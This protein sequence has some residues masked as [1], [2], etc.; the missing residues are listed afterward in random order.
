MPDGANGTDGP[1][2]APMRRKEDFRF[3]T[4]RGNYTDD[5]DLPRQAC[6]AFVRSPHA[7]AA[8]RSVDAAAAAAGPGVVAILTG[9]DL[10]A[11][12]L[13]GL[14]CGWGVKSKDGS[15]MIEPPWPAIAAD[16]VRFVGEIV[17]VAIAET[18]AEARDAAER[19][20]V[21][22]APLPAVAAAAEA[23]G[24]GAPQ[25]H[26]EAAGNVCFDWEFGDKTATDEAFAAAHHVARLSL[27]NQRLCRTRW[28]R[29]RRS[30]I[31]ISPAT[32]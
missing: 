15:P 10:A 25:L 19:V 6:A 23:N 7:H 22:Y 11:D 31:T 16:K 21:D 4:G 26:A 1:V 20:V 29:G 3:L 18:A 17:A 27:V 14:P 5:V 2:G 12:G 13:G 30:R 32:C 9:A 24:P 8:I 28:S